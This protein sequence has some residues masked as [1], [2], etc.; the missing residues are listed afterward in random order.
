MTTKR[1]LNAFLFTYL[2]IY[3]FIHLFIYLF[4]YEETLI[5]RA[6]KK[7]DKKARHNQRQLRLFSTSDIVDKYHIHISVYK[8]S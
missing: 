4:I 3:L 6:F 8:S 7:Y 5:W 2:F 1:I